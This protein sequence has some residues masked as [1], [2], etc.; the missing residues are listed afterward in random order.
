MS[1]ALLFPLWSDASLVSRR[2]QRLLPSS[3]TSR[4]PPL[5]PEWEDCLAINIWEPSTQREK[6]TAEMLWIYGGGFQVVPVVFEL[7]Y[8]F[9]SKVRHVQ[10]TA[11]RTRGPR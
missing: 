3:A 10:R 9:L 11:R 8:C 4:K 6:G 1:S 5:V 7:P 2:I